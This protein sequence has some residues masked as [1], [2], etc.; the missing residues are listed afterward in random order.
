MVPS[1][2]GR[3]TVQVVRLKLAIESAGLIVI[4]NALLAV[5]P[6]ESLIVTP[7]LENVP[8]A[9]GVPVMWMVL[10]LNPAVR[11][12]GSPD[13]AVTVKGAV[14]PLIVIAPSKPP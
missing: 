13:W 3:L 8:V 11:P 9:V 6:V 2:P 12:V 5:A 14:P 4:E 1:N 10:P 7:P